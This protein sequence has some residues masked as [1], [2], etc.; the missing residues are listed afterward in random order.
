MPS[1]LANADRRVLRYFRKYGF[2]DVK[3]ILYVL[4]SES[5]VEQSIELEQYFIDHY[6]S[7]NP[8]LNVDLV[9][10]GTKGIH[11]PM[12]LEVRE[13]LRKLRG[14]SFFVYDTLKY[15]LIYKFQSKQHA[16]D[17]IHI[18]HRTLNNCLYNSRLYLNR[19]MFSIEPISE[20][21]FV[22]IISLE[23]LNNLIQEKQRDKREIQIKSKKIYAEN[24]KQPSLSKVYNSIGSFA[25][26]IKGDRATIRSYINN[27]NDLYRKE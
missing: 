19:F 13:R 25:K 4:T 3:L 5:T 17:N 12:S 15:S 22:S 16:Y 8:L 14:T 23:N 6:N 11:T 26:A 10:G 27:K 21:P 7:T 9:A 1:I 24:I 2:K 20:F 18:D